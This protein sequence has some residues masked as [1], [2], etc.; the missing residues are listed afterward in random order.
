MKNKNK[1][2][3]A[4]RPPELNFDKDYSKYYWLIIPVLTIIYFSYSFFSNGFYQD[5]EVAHFINMRDF[6]SNPW[7][8]MSNWANPAGKY[9]LLYLHSA[10]INLFYF[11]TH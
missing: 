8:I 2:T 6:W 10:D 4:K 5:D 7:I 1:V 9:F 11:S 3:Q